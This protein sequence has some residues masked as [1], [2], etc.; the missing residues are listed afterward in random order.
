MPAE[1][2]AMKELVDE[3][4]KYGDILSVLSDDIKSKLPEGVTKL[5]ETITLKLANYD[6]GMGDVTLKIQPTSKKYAAGDKATV[7]IAL[8][9][10]KGGYIWFLIEGEGQDDGILLLHLPVNMA[11]QLANKTFV[12]MILE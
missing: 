3:A 4:I 10:G 5:V 9:D 2:T 6:S 7:A 12:T 11:A 1:T 8:P